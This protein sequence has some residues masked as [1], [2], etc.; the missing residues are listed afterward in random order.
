MKKHS[1]S[2]NQWIEEKSSKIAGPLVKIANIP[3][4]SAV[5]DGLVAITPVIIIGSLFLI[6]GILSQ[7]LVGDSGEPILGFLSDYSSKFFLVNDLTMGFLA[8]YASITISMGYGDKLKANAKTCGLLGL[9]TFLLINVDVI[10]EGT[11]AVKYFGATGLFVAIIVALV[12]VKIYSFLVAKKIMIRLP[13]SV[14]PNVGNAFASLIPFFIIFTLAWIVSSVLGFNFAG[15][16]ETLLLP[17]IS[18]AD[19]VWVFTGKMLVDFGLWGVGLHGGNMLSPIFTPFVTMW[20]AENATAAAAGNI[21]PHV[22]VEGMDRMMGWVATVWPLLL[23]LFRSK[24]KHHKIFA[25]A[26]IP[27]AIFGIVE[28]VI[29]GLPLALNPFLLVPYLIIIGITSFFSYLAIQV[30]LVAT[31]FISLPWAT[32]AP[33]LGFL[34]SGGSITP[35][36]LIAVNFTVGYF[37]FLPFFRVYERK[38]LEKQQQREQEKLEN[39][40]MQLV[41]G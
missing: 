19:N 16:F 4:I 31:F 12:S 34:A 23:L 10:K 35:I 22:W 3:A 37:I 13:D 5:Q 39:E 25:I 30:G 18:A 33:L 32:P 20:T 8:L 14:P 24:V 29:F 6:L 38:E 36:I 15:W 9:I 17:F 11:I 2:F 1:T 21:P 40:E 7:P 41:E 26:C 28:P 27:A